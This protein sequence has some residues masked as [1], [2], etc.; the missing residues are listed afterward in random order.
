MPEFFDTGHWNEYYTGA[1]VRIYFGDLLIDEIVSIEWHGTSTKRPVYGY[2]SR[3][4]DAV[5]QGQFLVR[6]AFMIPFK[7]VGYLNSVMKVLQGNKNA[8][9]AVRERIKR[10]NQTQDTRIRQLD[11]R[12]TPRATISTKVQGTTDEYIARETVTAM[13]PEL[14]LGDVASEGGGSFRDLVESFQKAVWRT[15]SVPEQHVKRPDQ[16]DA[17]RDGTIGE[18]FNVLVTYGDVNNPETPSTIETLIDLHLTDS[19]KMLDISGNVVYEQY[20]FFCRNVNQNVGRYRTIGQSTDSP[21]SGRI[22]APGA[23]PESPEQTTDTQ[24]EPSGVTDSA[25]SMLNRIS[26]KNIDRGAEAIEMPSA[27]TGTEENVTTPTGTKG[28]AQGSDYLRNIDYTELYKIL[29]SKAKRL[30]L[31]YKVQE[32]PRPLRSFNVNEIFVW[33]NNNIKNTDSPSESLRFAGLF[34]VEKETTYIVRSVASVKGINFLE[35][36]TRLDDAS[37]L[38][39][40]EKLT[41]RHIK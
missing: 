5:A 16:L 17:L 24:R 33:Y 1:Q 40:W 26:Q 2:A 18:G 29:D 25:N 4:Y 27:P 13:T 3:E 19:Q 8:V 9:D 22:G 38:W 35:L 10:E 36:V 31:P 21:G 20:Q 14:L 32:V 6:G 41:R 37:G 34:A 30:R 11:G 12:Y 7:E 28:N 23:S 15:T 39:I